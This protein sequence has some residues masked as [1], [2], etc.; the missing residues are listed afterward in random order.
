MI[1]VVSDRGDQ[2]VSREWNLSASSKTVEM[3][4]DRK[5][6]LALG[7]KHFSKQTKE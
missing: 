7:R 6:G 2:M 4:V 3:N 1:V 5:E